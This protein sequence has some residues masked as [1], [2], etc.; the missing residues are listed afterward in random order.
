MDNKLNQ[1][2]SQ[3]ISSKGA[4]K[5]TF[6]QNRFRHTNESQNSRSCATN[7]EKQIEQTDQKKIYIRDWGEKKLGGKFGREK[8]SIEGIQNLIN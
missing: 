7:R 5:I 6:L 4:E 2:P 3:E 8:I 1:K